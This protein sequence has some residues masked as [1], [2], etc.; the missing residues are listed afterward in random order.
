MLRLYQYLQQK[1]LSTALSILL[2]ISRC[3]FSTK[4]YS[5]DEHVGDLEMANFS[6]AKEDLNLKI[7][8]IL[9]GKMKSKRN[10][11][12]FASPWSAPAWMKTYRVR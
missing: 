9:C 5:Y 6:L 1:L 4:E 12:M 2:G 7:P 3:D 11:V 8:L 10:V